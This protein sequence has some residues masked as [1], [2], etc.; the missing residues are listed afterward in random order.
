MAGGLAALLDDVAVL[1]RKA[2]VTLDDV[3]ALTGQTATRSTALIIDDAAVTPS[4][5]QGASPARELP[6]IWRIT[7][8]SLRNK[9]LIVLPVI[10]LLSWLAPWVMSPILMLGGAYLA[11]EGAEKIWEYVTGKGH[12][13]H[14]DE[15]T[16]APKEGGGTP[17]ENEDQMVKNAI[18]TD[19]ILS[20]EIMVISYNAVADQPFWTRL[21]TLIAVGIIVTLGVYGV[22]G[23]LIKIDD[24]GLALVK[25]NNNEGA[26]AKFGRLMVKGM[27]YV[28]TVLSVIGTAAMLWVGGHIL[29]SGAAD[30]GWHWP[31]ETLHSFAELAGD[32]GFLAW[33]LD[34]LGSAIV[35]LVVGLVITAVVMS[36]H[37]ARADKPAAENSPA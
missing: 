29:I 4:L 16:P 23:L 6:V 20:A 5:V 3:A 1:A 30:L 22:V 8:G 14:R 12:G 17:A 28:L 25:K 11:F 27:P 32:N 7:K 36:V 34:T 10:L 33:L 15:K 13:E 19:L 31:A 18:T 24:M 35:G 26:A 2:A 9:L 21:L 37:K